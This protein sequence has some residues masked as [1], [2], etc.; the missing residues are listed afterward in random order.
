M[1]TQIKYIS[2]PRGG[3]D[4]IKPPGQTL[5]AGAGDC[6]DKA[7]LLVSMLESVGVEAYLGFQPGHSFALV[8]LSDD[9]SPRLVRPKPLLLIGNKPAY[10]LESTAEGAHV[11]EGRTKVS[12]I[13][14]IYSARTRQPVPLRKPST[15]VSR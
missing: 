10:L 14:A 7:I 9:V 6:E 8:V 5:E 13:T 2:D 1:S 15:R 12:E 4:Y 11:G 3:P